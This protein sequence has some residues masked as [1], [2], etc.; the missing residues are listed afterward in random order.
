M[1]KDGKTEKQNVADLYAGSCVINDVDIEEYVA[2]SLITDQEGRDEAMGILQEG[3][4]Y[5]DYCLE[6]FKAVK[7]LYSAGKPI[8]VFSVKS[9]MGALFDYAETA[10]ISLK[11]GSGAHVVQYSQYLYELYV[12]RY[13]ALLMLRVHPMIYDKTYPLDDAIAFIQREILLVSQFDESNVSN[14]NTVVEE[15]FK[16]M[17]RNQ[18]S[19]SPLTGIGTGLRALDD[20]TGGLQS[21]DLVVVAGETSSGKTSLAL[22]IAKNAAMNF[23]ARVVFYS[24]EMGKTQLAARLMSQEAGISSKEI[25]T[26]RMEA[27]KVKHVA[28]YTYRLSSAPIYF[29]DSSSANIGSITRSIRNMQRRYNVNLVVIDYLQLI[30]SPARGENREQQVAAI[31]R[32]LKNTA[33]ELSVCIVLLSQLSRNEKH[34]PSLSRLRDSGQIEEAADVILLTYRPEMYGIRQY[35]E[36]F[37]NYSPYGTAMIDIAKGRNIGTHQF[38]ASFRKEQTLFTDYR[39]GE[40][41]PENKPYAPF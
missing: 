23:G 24:L 16:V 15:V 5:N 14:I 8:D 38:I 34:K 18:S 17:K 31:A 9:Q 13:L 41:Q 30:S 28:D 27:D 20:F 19:Q 25:L 6:L 12:R 39:G 4:F 7:T 32:T 22:T 3:C 36:P 37:E 11:C 21:S 40:Y 35:E 33:K 29:D 2:G 1:T 26:Q 10:R